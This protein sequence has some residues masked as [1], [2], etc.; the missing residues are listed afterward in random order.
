MST[1]KR[2]FTGKL[3]TKSAA[4]KAARQKRVKEMEKA[5]RVQKSGG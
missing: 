5:N 4:E 1:A 2:P 3:K